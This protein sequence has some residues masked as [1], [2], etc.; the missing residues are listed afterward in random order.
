LGGSNAN[1]R[2]SG[3]PQKFDLSSSEIWLNKSLDRNLIPHDDNPV[4]QIRKLYLLRDRIGLLNGFEINQRSGTESGGGGSEDRDLFYFPMRKALAVLKRENVFHFHDGQKIEVDRLENALR[5]AT[6]IPTRKQL[7]DL[8]N[9]PVD[10]KNDPDD[11]VIWF[12]VPTWLQMSQLKQIRYG[13]HEALGLLR[14]PDP[15][16]RYST[17][18]EQY[19]TENAQMTSPLSEVQKQTVSRKAVFEFLQ[20]AKSSNENLV[21]SPQCERYDSSHLGFCLIKTVMEN[22]LMRQLIYLVE[23]SIDEYHADAIGNSRVAIL[24]TILNIPASKV[25]FITAM[26][27]A[28][29]G[30]T[31]VL[32][33]SD[34]LSRGYAEGAI[35]IDRHLCVITRFPLK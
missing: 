29:H 27:R 32:N 24:R 11:L 3:S 14:I 30:T 8:E 18:L 17:Q 12:N 10:L 9:A 7:Y 22:G 31:E 25:Q 23:G 19:V 13:L 1:P 35:V 6:V 2:L 15:L 34:C 20:E 21:L 33:K 16:Y 4:P 28:D 26:I 5:V